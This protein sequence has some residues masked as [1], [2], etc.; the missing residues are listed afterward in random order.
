MPL[1]KAS[2]TKASHPGQ[3]WDLHYARFMWGFYQKVCSQCEI[4][5][6]ENGTQIQWSAAWASQWQ[7]GCSLVAKVCWD[8]WDGR[9]LIKGYRKFMINDGW[10]WLIMVIVRIKNNTGQSCLT[11]VNDGLIFFGPWSIVHGL[12]WLQISWLQIMNQLMIR[13]WLINYQWL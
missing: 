5:P 13:Q 11:I 4:T 7:S 8:M 1:G 2:P 12:P 6:A 9:G 3:C 10:S